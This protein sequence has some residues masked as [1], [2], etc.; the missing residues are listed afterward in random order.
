MTL[1]KSELATARISRDWPHHL[2]L[3]AEKARLTNAEPGR[4]FAAT[5]P[6][7][8]LT[9]PSAEATPPPSWRSLSRSPNTHRRSPSVSGARTA[10]PRLLHRNVAQRIDRCFNFALHVQATR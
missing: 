1:C 2:A 8:A 4:G 7:A 3:P 10:F 5:L 9:Y 6:A